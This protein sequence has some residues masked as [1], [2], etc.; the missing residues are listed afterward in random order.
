MNCIAI[1]QPPIPPAHLLGSQVPS[2]V[3]D[4][5]SLHQVIPSLWPH[6][7]SPEEAQQPRQH[8]HLVPQHDHE[9][10]QPIFDTVSAAPLV[11]PI[12][13]AAQ[14][15]QVFSSHYYHPQLHPTHKA[16]P[17]LGSRRRQAAVPTLTYSIL[18]ALPATER[19]SRSN[20][21]QIRYTDLVTPNSNNLSEPRTMH[22][23]SVIWSRLRVLADHLDM[24]EAGKDYGDGPDG[25]PNEFTV[26][27][28]YKHTHVVADALE[29]AVAIRNRSGGGSGSS[30]SSGA[31]TPIITAGDLADGMFTMAL[32]AQ[33][34][35]LMQ[36]LF[37]HVR[38]V[39]AAADP[40]RDDTFAAWLLPEM[41]IGAAL[42]DAH[43]TFHMSLT[44]QLATQFLGRLR[45]AVTILCLSDI[46]PAGANFN[47]TA[48]AAT[49]AGPH[50][51]MIGIPA[52]FTFVSLKIQEGEL[53]KTLGQLQEELRKFMDTMDA[54]DAMEEDEKKKH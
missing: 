7:S 49:G 47:G 5:F 44:V 9:Q 22:Q 24:V 34:L 25:K 23:F 2:G 26:A 48:A 29:Q 54:I 42:I 6:Q 37:T 18:S 38:K 31:R 51:E 39:L 50:A 52:R 35:H 17:I 20:K 40:H 32:Y 14:Q 41:N 1:S 30:S 27:E 46:G 15:Q 45:E 10:Q 13:A 43:P 16:A 11:V 53:G 21:V 19:R 12:S 8:P 33:I 3:D 28:L 4:Y 36:R